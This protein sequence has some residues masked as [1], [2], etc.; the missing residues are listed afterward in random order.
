MLDKIKLTLKFI[1][2][3]TKLCF[4]GMNMQF[5]ISIVGIN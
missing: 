4:D 3:W 5:Q 1:D 2:T